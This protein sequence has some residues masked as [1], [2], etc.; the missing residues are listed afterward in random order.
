MN[1]L[2]S[3]GLI[4][5]VFLLFVLI[6]SSVQQQSPVNGLWQWRQTTNYRISQTPAGDLTVTVLR[7]NLGPFS[8]R[9]TGPNSVRVNFGPKCCTGQVSHNGTRIVWSNKTNWTLSDLPVLGQ[10]RNRTVATAATR[11]TKPTKPSS[12]DYLLRIANKLSDTRKKILALVFEVQQNV[13]AAVT[14][15]QTQ[16]KTSNVLTSL[17]NAHKSAQSFLQNA[18]GS[19]LNV[20]TSLRALGPKVTRK[21]TTRPTTRRPTTTRT[22]R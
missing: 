5:S 6:E 4:L 16:G 18:H 8:G 19:V 1:R 14:Y 12:A 7:G 17:N 22:L 9:V 11:P 13:Q 21:P 2:F 10:T 20:E 15:A 3:S